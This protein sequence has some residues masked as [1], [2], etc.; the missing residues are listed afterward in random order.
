MVRRSHVFMGVGVLTASLT[1]VA[2]GN[3]A[4]V[5]SQP[6]ATTTADATLATPGPAYKGP[7]LSPSEV[8]VSLPPTPPSNVDL[9]TLS[10]AQLSEYGLP[11][12]P[13]TNSPS[14]A[15][16]YQALSAA[17]T[18][19]SPKFARS[20]AAA[21]TQLY[22]PHWA[23]Y[24]DTNGPFLAAQGGWQVPN[25]YAS[26]INRYSATWVGIGSGG[27]M[28]DQLVQAGVEV[29]TQPGGTYSIF[30]WWENYD[31][32]NKCCQTIITNLFVLAHDNVFVVVWKINSSTTGIDVEN[33]T[34]GAYSEF[35]VSAYCSCT[36]AQVI[37][38][39]PTED[40]G[41]D[42]YPYMTTLGTTSFSNAAAELSSGYWW[43]GQL[44]NDEFTAY[45]PP[46]GLVLAFPNTISNGNFSVIRTNQD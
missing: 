38:E 10:D 31:P 8:G 27:S 3:T 6:P 32:N 33:V 15:G 37:E 13:P 18:Y 9:A 4:S 36:T 24:E 23:G 30:P 2:V 21:S 28:N 43:M 45:N 19:I 29:D 7:T 16:W 22:D 1:L 35:P 12:R 20:D 25:I 42:P 40:N 46:D 39:R 26:T 34:T 17:T 41:Q 5:A 14:Y 44:P 11:P